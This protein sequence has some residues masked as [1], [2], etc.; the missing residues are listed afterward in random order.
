MSERM[1]IATLTLPGLERSARHVRSFAR[2]ALG[3][4]HPALDDVQTCVNEA[5]TNGIE[6]TESGRGGKVTVTF[7]AERG[8]LV[9]EVT[10]D[11]A[12]GHRPHL[13]DEPLAENGRGMR[14]IDAL[15]LGWGL[16]ADG[17]RTT[18]WMRFP[19]IG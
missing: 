4:R 5:F 16:R 19:G 7:A 8:E 18:V 9:A 17:D 3:E 2:N 11:G 1:V 12:G 13:R 14:I 10:D 15:A 6:H